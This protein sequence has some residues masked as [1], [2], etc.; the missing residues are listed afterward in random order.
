MAKMRKTRN[1]LSKVRETLS[2]LRNALSK[3][4]N[5]LTKVRSPMSKVRNTLKVEVLASFLTKSK[6]FPVETPKYG[7]NF[8][9]QPVR[10]RNV[11]TRYLTSNQ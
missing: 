11:E 6:N 5:T 4:R 2:H 10:M 9:V 1:T 8:L 3:V 7:L